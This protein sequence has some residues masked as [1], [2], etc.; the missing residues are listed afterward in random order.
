M[1]C[2]HPQRT[3]YLGCNEQHEQEMAV[4]STAVNYNTNK[5]PG[6]VRERSLRHRGAFLFP[7]MWAEE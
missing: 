1:T 3:A 4:P 5:P 6:G 7:V 2:F